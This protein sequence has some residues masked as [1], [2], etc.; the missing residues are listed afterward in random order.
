LHKAGFDDRAIWDI[1]AV[2]SYSNMTN[3]MSS[4]LD[5]IP[6]VEYHFRDRSP[7]G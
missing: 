7:P 4:A 6:N 2:T 5:M 3:R 1:A